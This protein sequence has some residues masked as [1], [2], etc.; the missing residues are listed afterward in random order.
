MNETKQMEESKQNKESETNTG[1]DKIE[2][3][4]ADADGGFKLN[5]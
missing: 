2:H 4:Y 1:S 5:F 3:E